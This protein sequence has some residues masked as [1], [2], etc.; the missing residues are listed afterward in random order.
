MGK[1]LPRA[2][3]VFINSFE[4][5]DPGITECLKSKLKRFLNIGPSN[6]ISAPSPVAD[7][8]G[9]ITWLDKQKLASV[10]YVSF[11]SVATPPPHELVAV[12]EALETRAHRTMESSIG[13][14]GAWSSWGVCDSLRLEFT[15]RE[16]SRRRADDLQA[17]FWRSEAQRMHDRGCVGDW[18]QG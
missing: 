9:C 12:A 2:A 4:E 1:A 8:S 10:A 15:A 7:T 11:G 6:L 13:S 3:A 17:I 16:Y 5:L 14:L 18:S